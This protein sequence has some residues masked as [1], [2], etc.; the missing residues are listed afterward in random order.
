MHLVP[1]RPQEHARNFGR[2]SLHFAKMALLQ[3]QPFIG[4]H[5]EVHAQKCD[6]RTE[7][8]IPEKFPGRKLPPYYAMELVHCTAH[9]KQKT[10]SA[11]QVQAGF[12]EHSNP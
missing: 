9:A 8:I 6:V 4:Q 12:L 5:Y 7:I 10:T 11:S 3:P 1:E 2:A